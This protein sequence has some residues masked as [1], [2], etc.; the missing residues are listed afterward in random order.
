MTV[1]TKP[2]SPY[3]IT[4][5]KKPPKPNNDKD[6]TPPKDRQFIPIYV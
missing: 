1:T 3:Y 4:P 6:K 2:I 5:V